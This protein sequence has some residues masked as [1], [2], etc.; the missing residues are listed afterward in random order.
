[1]INFVTIEQIVDFRKSTRSLPLHCV[2]VQALS[3][4]KDCTQCRLH[5]FATR[6][7]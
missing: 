4:A 3:E 2:R 6:Q 1:M 7:S 5:N